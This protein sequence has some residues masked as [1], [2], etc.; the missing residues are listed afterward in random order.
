M[1]AQPHEPAPRRSAPISRDAASVIAALPEDRAA[2]F[3]TEWEAALDQARTDL[4]LGSL[5]QRLEKITGDYWAVA[6]ASASARVT[7]AAT[8]GSQWR[9]G[10]DID[11]IPA[12]QVLYRIS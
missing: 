9:A 6:S 12:E 8:D 2:S 4:D 3:R 11:I 1:S 10:Q 5:T 7:E